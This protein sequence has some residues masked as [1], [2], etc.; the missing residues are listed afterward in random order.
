MRNDKFTVIP[1]NMQAYE[2]S[3]READNENDLFRVAFDDSIRGDSSC[4]LKT[5]EDTDRYMLAYDYFRDGWE[6]AVRILDQPWISVKVALPLV[7][8]MLVAVLDP[9]NDPKVW[10]AQWDAANKSFSSAG[11]WF[12]QDEVTHW[13]PLPEQPSPAEL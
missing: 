4:S 1:Q 12:E 6:A 9:S 5:P 13:I 8:G 3:V 2:M 10:P 7:D 11:G